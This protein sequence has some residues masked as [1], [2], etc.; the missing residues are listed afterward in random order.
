MEMALY[1]IPN[2]IINI[3]IIIFQFLPNDP[4]INELPFNRAMLM[5]VGFVESLNFT[6]FD[7]VVFHDIDHLAINVKN[8]YGCDKM[9]KHFISGEAIWHWK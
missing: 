1:Q 6:N 2:N 8:Y 5:N 9:P 4:Q 3:V 7:C